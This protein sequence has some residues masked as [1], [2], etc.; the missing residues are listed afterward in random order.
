M[1][2][3]VNSDVGF[4]NGT[5]PSTLVRDTTVNF[6]NTGAAAVEISSNQGTLFPGEPIN[7]PA[8]NEDHPVTVAGAVGDYQMRCRPPYAGSDADACLRSDLPATTNI[9][10]ISTLEERR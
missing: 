7:V 4:V 5:Y 9:S 3:E 1:S 6:K 8:D 2:I 10:V